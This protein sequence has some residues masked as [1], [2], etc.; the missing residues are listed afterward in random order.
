MENEKEKLE[1]LR[2]IIGEILYGIN[3]DF[4]YRGHGNNLGMWSTSD[5]DELKWTALEKT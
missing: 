3:S 1:K 5:E 4:K 2:E